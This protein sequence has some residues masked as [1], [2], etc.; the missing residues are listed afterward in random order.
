MASSNTLTTLLQKATIDD[1][2]EILKACNATLK[3]SKSDTDALRIRAVAYLKLDRFEDALKAFE[4]GGDTVQSG[5]EIP[6][7]YALYKCGQL[8]KAAKVAASI[9]ADH[10]A[11]HLEAQALYRA[12]S[13]LQASQIYAELVEQRRAEEQLDL[14]VN[15]GAVDAQLQ[16]SGSTS[17]VRNV[18]PARE[19]MENF[20][21]AYNA[22]CGSLARGEL[23]Q[24]EVL[25]KR[26]SEL[27]KHS[28]ELSEEEKA[29]ELLPITAQHVYVLL[30]TGKTETAAKVLADINIDLISDPSTRLIAQNNK[31]VLSTC[32]N[33]FLQHK[34]YS[35]K[36]PISAADEPFTFQST[37]LDFNAKTLDLQAFQAR[38]CCGFFFD[39]QVWCSSYCIT[40]C[41]HAVNI[42]RCYLCSR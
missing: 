3:K 38:C 1:H 20:E 22:A 41:Q 24:A 2:E 5:A 40:Y 18:R 32:T 31:A 12:E 42:A 34:T 30:R 17:G 14:R 10:G 13:A 15:I 29:S 23:G 4:D 33:P 35:K 9:S 8:D 36:P 7:A 28:E 16:W 25:L 19:D 26:S 6:Y 21:T 27:C 37:I 39:N 11:R